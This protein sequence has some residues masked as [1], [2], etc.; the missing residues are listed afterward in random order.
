LLHKEV[1]TRYVFL[2]SGKT[3]SKCTGYNKQLAIGEDSTNQILNY[4]KADNSKPKNFSDF[5]ETHPGFSERILL[6]LLKAMIKTGTIAPCQPEETVEKMEPYCGRLN[7]Y[8]CETS[9]FDKKI[10]YLASPLTGCGFHVTRFDQM[11]LYFLRKGV[12]EKEIP[13]EVQRVLDLQ[14]EQLLED[15]KPLKNEADALK[16]FSQMYHKFVAEKQ[17][18]LQTLHIV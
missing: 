14:N 10:N 9:L 16:V 15:G 2:E 7:N 5:T 6:I 1:A 4:L 3:A 13:K 12:E 8:I 11:F 18:L 17:P